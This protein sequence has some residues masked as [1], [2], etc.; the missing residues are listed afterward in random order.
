M[1]TCA[2][3][4]ASAGRAGKLAVWRSVRSSHSSAING[5]G[6]ADPSTPSA[7][8]ELSWQPH[9]ASHGLW[10]SGSGTA[11]G[12]RK[13]GYA[14][15][16]HCHHAPCTHG[17]R[18]RHGRSIIAHVVH[19]AALCRFS[20]GGGRLVSCHLSPC[21]RPHLHA[22]GSSHQQALTV[23]DYGRSIGCST[24][25][26]GVGMGRQSRPMWCTWR[27][28]AASDAGANTAYHVSVRDPHIEAHIKVSHVS[29]KAVRSCMQEAARSPEK[30]CEAPEAPEAL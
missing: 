11:G 27:L 5:G 25:G 28:C 20:R 29:C 9:M 1:Y 10:Y 30:P 18:S 12:I 19:M 21:I 24:C 2:A 22:V 14:W 13:W 17:R 23:T 26:Y 8:C 7:V 15:G 6:D 3:R 4:S 16:R